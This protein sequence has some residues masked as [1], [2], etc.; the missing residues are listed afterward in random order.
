MTQD[1]PPLPPFPDDIEDFKAT[2]AQRLQTEGQ[3]LATLLHGLFGHPHFRP[4]QEEVC[5]AVMEGDDALVVMPTGAGKSL[6][7][8]LP[9]L[10]KGGSALVISP[11]IALM[12]DQVAKLQS[13]GIAAERL[14]SGRDRR[15]SFVTAQAWRQGNLD[16]LF[17]APERL[18]LQSF[19]DLIAEHG[20]TLVAV[21]EAHC[22]SHWGHDFRPD[23]RLVGERL[24][25]PPGVP[26]VALTA[27]ATPRVQNDIIEKLAIPGARRF[28]RGFRRTNLSIEGI[29]AP[30][31]ARGAMVKKVISDPINRPALIYAPTR[32]ETEAL[33]AELA[34]V[35]PSA[36]YHAGLPSPQRDRVQADYL[37]GKLEIVVATIAFGYG[38][39]QG[40]YPHR[41]PHRSAGNHRGLLPGDRSSRSG[42][43]SLAGHSS[44]VLGR[45]TNP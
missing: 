43:K 29:E 9:G 28:I 12:E 45:S 21:D 23:Y 36:A 15:D 10:A 13:L 38:H 44:V 16:F 5:Q 11:L 22:I 35:A 3:P 27:T 42:R 1:P 18:G 31:S 32:K 8:Q 30:P 40:R 33:A 20:P 17:I 2:A 26:L 19:Q 25:R 24:P 39:R 14:H 41:L 7:Y 6:C 34:D 4:H 37:C